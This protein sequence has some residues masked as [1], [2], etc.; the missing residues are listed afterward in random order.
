[1]CSREPG[2]YD[3]LA[4]EVDVTIL[5]YFGSGDQQLLKEKTKTLF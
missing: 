4:G 2:L 3:D 1:M 5:N